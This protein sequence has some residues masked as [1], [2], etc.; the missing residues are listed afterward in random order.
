MRQFFTSKTFI[1]VLLFGVVSAAAG[2]AQ[3][4]QAKPTDFPYLS[5]TAWAIKDFVERPHAPNIVFLGSSLMLVPLDGVDADYLKQR[6]DGSQH[7]QSLY[8]EDAFRAKTGVQA[9]TFNFALPGEMP[10]D[11]YM[12]TNFLLRDQKKPEVLVYGVGPR[13]FM[14]NLLPSPSATDPYKFLSRFGDVSTDASRLMPEWTDRMNYELGRA[15]YLYGRRFD[16][17]DKATQLAQH[18]FERYMPAPPDGRQIGADERR[19]LVPDYRPF[20]LGKNQAFFRPTTP[21]ERKHFADNLAEYRKRYKKL[22][23][24]TFL[25]QMKFLED[26]LAIAKERGIHPVVVAMPITDLNR[27]LLSDFN[28]EAY[29]NALRGVAASTGASF[30]DFSESSAF[31]LAD[32]GDTV[33]LHSGGGKRLMDLIVERLAAD[34]TV[35]TALVDEPQ[36]RPGLAQE[37][38]SL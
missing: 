7:H 6:I 4:W 5:W 26:T 28:W 34:T 19:L 36:S 35:R 16:L 37:G 14:D 10:S 38:G 25:T 20:E 31:S 13:D 12:I 24:D 33:H 21:E 18:N 22:K 9:S 17:S 27:S 1:A 23:W 2:L 3:F 11:A 29:R 30:I 32:F 15:I 8:F